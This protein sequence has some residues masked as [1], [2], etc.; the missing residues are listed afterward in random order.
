MKDNQLVDEYFTRTLAIENK[1]TSQ[2]ERIKQTTI[3][4]KVLMSMTMKL[5]YVLSSIEEPNDV[6]TISIDELQ[7]TIL[8]MS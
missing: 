1:M 3:D 8:C 7:S 2:G 5:N 4:E 6:T